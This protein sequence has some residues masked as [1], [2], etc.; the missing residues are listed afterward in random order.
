MSL[1]VINKWSV[2]GEIGFLPLF[3]ISNL[4]YKVLAHKFCVETFNRW[5]VVQVTAVNQMPLNLLGQ[6]TCKQLQ[7]SREIAILYSN[8]VEKSFHRFS[9]LRNHQLQPF[10]NSNHHHYEPKPFTFR[11][12]WNLLDWNFWWFFGWALFFVTW[13]RSGKINFSF[14]VI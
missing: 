5:Y 11:G 13:F 2:Y 10:K 8:F 4:K 14:V 3:P 9:I 12:N 1:N 7:F 6:N